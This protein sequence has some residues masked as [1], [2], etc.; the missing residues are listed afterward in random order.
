MMTHAERATALL[1]MR[2]A[3]DAFYSAATRIGNHPFIE[4]TGLM[5]EYIKACQS[6]H[7]RGIDFSE[8]N[9][10]SGQDLPLENFEVAYIN[11]KL[12]CI[13][14]GRSVMSHEPRPEPNT[15]PTPPGSRSGANVRLRNKT[16]PKRAP[17]RNRPAKALKPKRLPA[18]GGHERRRSRRDS[19]AHHQPA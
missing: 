2:D 13:F 5:N 16:G 14:T 7:A 17:R 1:Q 4:F 10:H 9:T 11:E 3:A 15:E 8:C 6:A 12:E 18:E 19:R